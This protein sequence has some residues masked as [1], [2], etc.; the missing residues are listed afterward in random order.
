MQEVSELS[1]AQRT[2][3]LSQV[4]DIE[5]RLEKLQRNLPGFLEPACDDGLIT[6][7]MLR[8]RLEE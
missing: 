2:R 1:R 7:R 4:R 6:M 8:E 5:E 3:L